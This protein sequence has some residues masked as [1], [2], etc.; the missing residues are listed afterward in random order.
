MRRGDVYM[1]NLDPAVGSEQAKTRPV[2]IVSRDAINASSPVVIIV[3]V[4]S[5]SNKIRIYPTHVELRISE[6][7]LTS[8]SV[9]LCEQVRAISRD[10]LARHLGQLPAAKVAQINASLKIALD[11]DN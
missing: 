5:R 7:G 6:G 4:T 3:P 9:A 2:V 11:L 10:R 8:D 1:A